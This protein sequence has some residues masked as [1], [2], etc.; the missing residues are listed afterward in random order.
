MLESKGPFRLRKQGSSGFTLIELIIVISIIGI[1]AAVALPRMI[2]AQRDARVA[3]VNAIYGS[4]RS[5]AVLA[6]SRCELDLAGTA[7][8]V[9]AVNCASTTPYVN[10]EGALVRITYRYPSASADGIDTA[11]QINLNSDG[12]TASNSST[13]TAT[14]TFY[15]TGGASNLC[16]V[17]YQEA[18]YASGVY[19][20]P[21]M[22]PTY[23]GC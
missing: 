3:K 16:N 1:L 21:V 2:D 13:G 12:L 15:I 18:T 9:T 6:H 4:L 8:S 17:T 22:T 11:A 5:A 19:Y 7:T 10:M 14:R 20:A 23:S